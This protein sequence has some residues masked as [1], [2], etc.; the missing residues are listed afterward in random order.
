[1]K[2]YLLIAAA[3][4]AGIVSPLA[5]ARDLVLGFSQLGAESA[6]RLANTQSIQESAAAAK[7]QLKFANA[8]QKQE[9]QIKAIRAFIQ[10]KVD[11]IAFAPVVTTGWDE[12]L[13]EAQQ[14][15]IPVILTDRSIETHDDGY[16][17]S[18]L[19]A[20]FTEE[21]RRAGRWLLRNAPKTGEVRI[22][23]LQGS[24]GSA[25]AIERKRGFEEVIRA[26]PRFRIVRS[27]TADFTFAKGKEVMA[28]FLKAEGKG[29]IHVLYAH[30]DDMALG[31][32]QAIEEAGQAP[33]KDIL[34]IG[35]DAVKSAFEAMATGKMNVSVECNPLIGP[36][37]MDLVRF[38]AEG[39]P[40][41]KRV[42]TLEGVFPMEVA[43][44]ELPKRKY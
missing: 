26:D 10:Q 44:R 13:R 14:A 6:W 24:A 5:G 3:L 9:N 41:P 18:F 36:Q 4:I 39:K 38:A 1:M 43:K 17:L 35:V 16:Y 2:K 31:A 8:D 19:G 15:G 28:S 25:P 11:V 12:V 21:G 7:I 22:V 32:I 20:D 40:M 33:A 34:V 27:Q 30:N 42:Q 37:L 23:E 29:K